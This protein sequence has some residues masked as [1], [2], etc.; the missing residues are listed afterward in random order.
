M[1]ILSKKLKQGEHKT[2]PKGYPKERSQYAVP[3][4]YEFPIDTKKHVRAALAYFDKHTWES[5]SMKK[6]AARRILTAAKKFNI[7]VSEDSAVYRTVYPEANKSLWN[8]SEL[9]DVASHL[10]N[11]SESLGWE[12]EVEKDPRDVLNSLRTRKMGMDICN[13]ILDIVKEEME[14]IGKLKPVQMESFGPL[15]H[16]DGN[17]EPGNLSTEAKDWGLSLLHEVA[18]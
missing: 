2:P 9:T 7:A 6:K 5:S 8:V 17:I 10:F 3:E 1:T 12:A 15:L 13:L 18:P 14:E 4:Y 16:A 11:V